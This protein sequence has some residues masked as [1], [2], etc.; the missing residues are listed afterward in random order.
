MVGWE[1]IPIIYSGYSY[2]K[3]VFNLN[4]KENTLVEKEEKLNKREQELSNLEKIKEENNI[5][6]E[7]MIDFILNH[8]DRVYIH[9]GDSVPSP[10]LEFS[11][12]I[13][14]RSLFDLKVKKIH[15]KIHLEHFGDL[16]NIE[17]SEL[18]NLPHQQMINHRLELQL[19]TNA[20]NILKSIKKEG[21]ENIVKFVLRDVKIDFEGEKEFTKQGPYNLD[22]EIPVERI[23]VSL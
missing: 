14:N 4:E 9:A 1:S 5:Q 17:T 15:M 8:N 7:S 19:H 11:V 23:S 16:E 22:L 3:K 2:F 18:L 12:L 20:I 10:K 13:T 21:K 6:Y